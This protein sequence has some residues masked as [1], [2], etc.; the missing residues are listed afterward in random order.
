MFTPLSDKPDH[1]S[2]EL[3]VL[4]RWASDGTFEQLRARNRGGPKFSFF[5]GPVT[6]NKKL[7]VHTAWGRTLK[8]VFQRYKAM[9][10]F[11]QRYQ[12]GFD[13]QGLWIEVGV[14]RQLGLNSKREI[15]EY[16]LEE[17]ARKCRE[18]V[19]ESA[20]ALTK[21]SQRLGMWMDWGAD[22]YTFSDTN[23]EY[24]WRMLKTVHERGWLVKGHRSTEW[25][26][27]CGTSL[28]QHELSQS[29]VYQDRADPSLFVRLPVTGRH[30]E[31][32]V[33]WTTTPWTL[34]ANVAVAVHPDIEYGRRDNGEWVAVGRYPG[35][36]FVEK[37]PGSALVGWTYTGP[38][39]T[40]PP[41]A[42]V[43]HRVIPWDEVSLD[44]GT[45]LVHI[46]PGCGGED[47]ELSRTL[48]LAVLTPVDESGHFYDDYGWLHGLGTTES[49]DQITGDLAERGFLVE[50]KL[51]EHRYP[52]C[53]RC[54][55]PLIFRIADD[56]LI[57]VEDLRQPLLDANA[58]VL[59]CPSTWG[60]AWTTGCAT[61]ATGTSPGAATTGCRCLSTRAPA[62]T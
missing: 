49:A 16:G 53:W 45:G 1:P 55:T 31:S 9:R 43:E 40:L 60:S 20:T 24:V 19:I 47:F 39:D 30:G 35:E 26:P 10:G 14:E 41:G 12:N 33:V 61:W 38:F 28:S 4:E 48:G 8:D 32:L 51:Y 11:D 18:V 58:T 62:A 42:G 27:R 36:E 13:C 37:L 34:P 21:G 17:F 52:H 46:A 3:E 6:A 50:A 2:L 29:G 5:D 22:Y 7:A 57:S 56:W 23:I 44:E 54:D 25:C 59:G 15:E